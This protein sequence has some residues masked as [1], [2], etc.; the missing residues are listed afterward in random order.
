MFF[1]RYRK[2]KKLRRFLCDLNRLLRKRYGRRR[3]YT[4]GQIK[5]TVAQ[6]KLDRKSLWHGYLCF[7]DPIIANRVIREDHPVDMDEV[8]A[9]IGEA[10][11]LDADEFSV[12]MI[13]D[14]VDSLQSS[15]WDFGFGGDFNSGGD[16]GFDGGD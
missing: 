4:K 15:G 3:Y 5:R 6:E 2:K 13:Q 8:L 12:D 7:V 10:F 1:K 16:S 9:D 14:V 11:S